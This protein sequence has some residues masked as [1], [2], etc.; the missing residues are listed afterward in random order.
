[1][2]LTALPP[3]K[4]GINLPQNNHATP[5]SFYLDTKLSTT[6]EQ[7]PVYQVI[8]PDITFDY[9][10][11]LGRKLD[12]NGEPAW[13]DNGTAIIMTGST[14]GLTR[15]LVVWAQ[16]GAI[17]YGFTNPDRLYPSHT[18]VL[19]APDTSKKLAY[20]YLKKL[21]LLPAGYHSFDDIKDKITLEAGGAYNIIDENT[22]NIIQKDA[23]FWL[24]SFPFYIDGVTATGPGAKIEVSI[25][26]NGELVHLVWAW[27][28]V[29]PA[30]NGDTKS[31]QQAFDDIVNDRGSMDI[32]AS[33]QRVLINKVTLSYWINPIS[34]QQDYAMPVYIFNGDCLD[35]NGGY[36]ESFHAWTQALQPAY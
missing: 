5:L 25:G 13:E 8:Q 26:E 3:G 14:E 34:E 31:E 15:Q 9:V 29:K 11:T 18:P 4:S 35:N 7:V 32:P 23:S 17:E 22:G 6:S 2:S 24:I 27:R 33:C 1:M 12:F 20:D 21:D 16:S 28:E 19:P 30:Y 10:R 36:M